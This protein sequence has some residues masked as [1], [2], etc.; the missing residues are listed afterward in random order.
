MKFD[1]QDLIHIANSIKPHG[2]NGHISFRLIPGYSE[3]N[4]KKDKPVFLMIGG[5]PVPFFVEDKKNSGEYVAVKLKFIDSSEDAQK[6]KNCKIYS[7]DAETVEIES[8]ANKFELLDYAVYDQKHGF[9]GNINNFNDIPGNPVFETQFD[10]KTI[11]IPYTQDLIIKINHDTKSVEINAP[12]GLIEIY[13]D[14]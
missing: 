6:Y 11:I 2:L 9:I 4:F 3:Q 1:N 8:D 12:E 5:I 13:L 14:N 10:D 7:F